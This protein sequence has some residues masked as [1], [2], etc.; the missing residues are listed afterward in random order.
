MTF[1]T[2]P[3]YVPEEKSVDYI[4][5]KPFDESTYPLGTGISLGGMAITD[6]CVNPEV[7]IAWADYFYTEEGGILARMGIEDVSYVINEDGTYSNI[8][9]S[10][11]FESRI[12]QCTLMGASKLPLLVPEL[13]WNTNPVDSP[14][15]ANMN[16]ELYGS[17]GVF[18][19]GVLVPTQKF[20]ED[21]N[22]ILSTLSTDIRAY[23]ENYSAEVISGLVSLDDTW[24]DFQQT[25]KDMGVHELEGIYKAA[26]ERALAVQ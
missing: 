18:S 23:V 7:L 10:D 17:D 1:G 12:Y 8:N 6:K 21:E 14:S 19:M 24:D 13:Y 26:Y 16:Q 22:E 3:T 20:T 25:L 9:E 5:L 4:T 11:R 15:Q 2:S